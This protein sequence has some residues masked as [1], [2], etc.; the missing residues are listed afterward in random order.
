M[1]GKLRQR[2]RL[3]NTVLGFLAFFGIIVLAA[4]IGQR[5][6]MRLDLTENKRYSLSEQSRNI[7]RSLE[8]DVHIKCF[9]QEASRERERTR[10]LLETYRYYSKKIHYEF[11]DPDRRPS[12][13]RRYQIRTYGTLVLE[14][15]GKSQTVTT[16][17]E[18]GISNAILK[19]AQE[20]EKLVYFLTGHGEREIENFDQTGYSSAK[21]AIEK[22]N[23]RV[24][25]LNLLVNPT[26][27]EDAALVVAAGPQKPL[28]APEI[29]ALRDY[30]NR[31][32]SVMFLLEP[33]SDGGL[34]EL[35]H[36]C[37]VSLASD[38]VVDTMSRVFGADYLMPVITEY[39][40]HKITDGFN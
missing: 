18:E 6:P 7:V 38:I 36:S 16:A 2:T 30:L 13:A 10:D 34:K 35:L 21:A 24:K 4:L 15:F 25:T 9:F 19:L 1:F 12:L 33:F 22:E 27:P 8:E 14:G 29:E 31:K 40:Y 39:G 20:D 28:L 37:G 17:E 3:S 11:I 23:L 32:G 26:V 5:H